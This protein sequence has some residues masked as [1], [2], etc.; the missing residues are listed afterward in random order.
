MGPRPFWKLF[1]VFYWR[2]PWYAWSAF[3]H[4]RFSFASLG[5]FL[6]FTFIIPRFEVRDHTC[7]CMLKNHIYGCG[8]EFQ[9]FCLGFS[10]ILSSRVSLDSRLPPPII[11][12]KARLP[13]RPWS[14][15]CEG[16]QWVCGQ[17][18]GSPIF[19]VFQPWG[20]TG[21]TTR[22]LHFTNVFMSKKLRGPEP[23]QRARCSYP[24]IWYRLL[25]RIRT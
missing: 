1:D 23:I 25:L 17:C 4:L 21:E 15:L 8:Q 6:Y 11:T 13:S 10:A 2:N 7:E 3:C 16:M 19:T 12:K 9:S 24:M 18:A 20:K 14:R 22:S 5:S